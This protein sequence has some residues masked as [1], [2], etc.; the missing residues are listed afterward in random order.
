MTT[1]IEA[2]APGERHASLQLIKTTLGALA[3]ELPHGFLEPDGAQ[4]SYAFNPPTMGTRKRLGALKGRKDLAERPGMHTAYWLATALSHLDGQ[5]DTESPQRHTAIVFLTAAF[6]GRRLHPSR[7]VTQHNGR[8]HL[9]AMLPTRSAAPL[10]PSLTLLQQLLGRQT[11]WVHAW[12][13]VENNRTHA[14]AAR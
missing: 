11:R 12:V 13:Q 7:Y 5:P 9:V 4:T 6:G 10:P 8:F 14:N 3:G 1:T 2:L